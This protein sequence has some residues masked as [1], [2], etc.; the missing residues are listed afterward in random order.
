[1]IFVNRVTKSV[2]GSREP[3]RTTMSRIARISSR[4]LLAAAALGSL[5]FGT[6]QAFAAPPAA[7]AGAYCQDGWCA[8]Q[9]GG[10]GFCQR[11]ACVCY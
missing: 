7:E 1:M 9:C 11:G 3:R 8:K 10:Y 6:A 4:I 5:G 2:A